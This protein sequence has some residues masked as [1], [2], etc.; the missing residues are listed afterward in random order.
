METNWP[1]LPWVTQICGQRSFEV[2]ADAWNME[3]NEHI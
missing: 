1:V 2:I 3:S